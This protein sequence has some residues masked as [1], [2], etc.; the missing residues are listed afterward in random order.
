MKLSQWY[1]EG[2]LSGNYKGTPYMTADMRS[3]IESALAPHIRPDEDCAEALERLL[4]ERDL[5]KYDAGQAEF[6]KRE[7]AGARYL[8]AAVVADQPDQKLRV[9]R[10][11]IEAVKGPRTEIT[12]VEDIENGDTIYGVI[13]R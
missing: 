9:S 4:R 12:S 1:S 10:K 6:A 13:L 8:F 2:Q 5:N 11:A 3:K 7:A